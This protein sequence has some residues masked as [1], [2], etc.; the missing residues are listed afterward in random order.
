MR[1]NARGFDPTNLGLT[2]DLN[3]APEPVA[4]AELSLEHYAGLLVALTAA[5][6]CLPFMRS[7]FGQGDE[8][9]WLHAANR[10]ND[11]QILYRDFFEFHPPLG[12]L[13]VSGWTALFGPSLPAARFFMLLI[14]AMTAWLAY[15]CCR[16]ISNRPGLSAWLALTWVA[17]SQGEW[18]AVNHHW[19]TSFFS[20]LTLWAIMSTERKP[21]RL[22]LAGLAAS[23]ATLV[24]THRGGL[25]VVAGLISLLPRRSAKALF[26]Y[27]GSGASLLF[28]IFCFLWSQ[29]AIGPAFDQVIV[30]A[31]HSYVQV[32]SV[33]FGAFVDVQT[34]LAVAAF[35]LIVC[36]MVVAVCRDGIGLL[37][38]P[39]WGAASLFALAGFLGCFPR[40]DAVHIS[41]CVVLALPLLCGLFAVLLPKGW[42]GLVPYALAI[43]TLAIPLTQLLMIANRV[44][45]APSTETHAGRV[46]DVTQDGVLGLIDRL[47]TLQPQDSVYFYP[48]DPLLPFLTGR[49]H[50]ARY[51][52]LLPQYSTPSQYNETC[53][54]VMAKAQWVVFDLGVSRPSY[55]RETF[56]AIS[57]PSP[58]EKVA[59]EAALHEGFVV[60][61]RYGVY[62]LLRRSRA[63]AQM[64]NNPALKP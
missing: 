64:C 53:L 51:D 38:R 8:G 9:I 42:T 52:I 57:D 58:Q 36:L 1:K 50:P 26:I 44:S 11:G 2:S 40:P 33:K 54:E 60:D 23:A 28:A 35:P 13:I 62:Q 6:F 3:E 48:Y 32:Q 10:M 20:L 39:H 56:P 21:G 27:T 25:V 47:N 46:L 14:V 18:T 63:T 30:Y 61:A 22:A 45:R 15:A 24:T 55:Y 16:I 31:T 17:A 41:F 5:L 59:F 37:R 7:V 12:F 49:R 34:L 19:L 4:R 29:G 43:A